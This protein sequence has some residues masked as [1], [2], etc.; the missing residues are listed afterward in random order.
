MSSLRYAIRPLTERD[1][2]QL[3]DFLRRFFL[4]DEHLNAAV[5]LMAD[6]R[7][8]CPEQEEFLLDALPHGL[9]LQAEDVETGRLLGVIMNGLHR[10]GHEE[11]N[12]RRAEKLRDPAFREIRRFVTFVDLQVSEKLRNMYP[13]IDHHQV[14]VLGGSVDTAVRRRG[15]ITD[16]I[17]HSRKIGKE[18]GIP[19]MRADCSSIYSIKAC[20]YFGFKKIFSIRYDTYQRDGK[21]VFPSTKES[22]DELAT[23]VQKL[24]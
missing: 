21:V 11:E 3:V 19:L 14:E 1:G 17:E 24:N 13:D 22:G 20:E 15:I 12:I 10:A 4:R 2:P 8:S 16:L 7:H 5:G 18:K 9:S 6:G 23:Y